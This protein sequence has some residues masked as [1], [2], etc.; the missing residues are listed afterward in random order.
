MKERLKRR[1]FC[2]LWSV[3]RENLVRPPDNKEPKVLCHPFD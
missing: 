2:H 1:S 3:R